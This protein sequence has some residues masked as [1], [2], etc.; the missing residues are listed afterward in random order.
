MQGAGYIGAYLTIMAFKAA[1]SHSGVAQFVIT[2]N[3]RP[4]EEDEA[5]MYL[6]SLP[7]PLR[8]IGTDSSVYIE[9]TCSQLNQPIAPGATW[10]ACESARLAARNTYRGAD[11]FQVRGAGDSVIVV[12]WPSLSAWF[13]D[14]ELRGVSMGFRSEA[15]DST[16]NS[17]PSIVGV[18]TFGPRPSSIGRAYLF[19][20]PRPPSDDSA[21]P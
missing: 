8:C 18:I 7:K 15:P 16:A 13:N 11:R 20:D 12:E 6:A 9:L 2:P 21:P 4:L 3:P 19:M 14:Y 17:E 5:A 10:K 1:G